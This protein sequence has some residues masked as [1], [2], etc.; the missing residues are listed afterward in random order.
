[1]TGMGH[2]RRVTGKI[3]RTPSQVSNARFA[4]EGA[5]M[6]ILQFLPHIGAVTSH[7]IAEAG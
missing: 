4:A 7:R 6:R 2:I 1:M 5:D 3:T